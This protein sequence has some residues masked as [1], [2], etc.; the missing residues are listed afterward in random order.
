MLSEY[1]QRFS[2]YYT[3]LNRA[4]YLFRSGRRESR[5]LAQIFSEYSD[6][7]QLST[8]AELRAALQETAEYRET[9]RKSIQ[10][11]IA[12]ALQGNLASR[13]RE[14][15]DEIERYESN[16]RIDWD[17]VKIGFNRAS[18]LSAIE[19]EIIRRRDLH[20]RRADLITGSQDLRN[21]RIELLH[22]A[23][24][25]LNYETYLAMYRELRGIDYEKLAEQANRLLSKT[26]SQYVSALAPLLA[27]EAGT[28]LD[29]ATPPDAAY[30][31]RFTRFDN[32]FSSGRMI[33]VYRELC[34]GFGFK[35]ERQSNVE[36]EIEPQTGG[37]A[38][39]FSSP[40]RVPEEIKF[41]VKVAGGQKNYREF[42]RESGR[43][44]NFAW[45]SRQLYPE[46]R[47][48]AD[49]AVPEAWGMLLESLMLDNHWLLGTFGFVENANFR[50]ALELFRL[51]LL[52]R[53][54]ARLNYE[55]EFHA[56]RLSVNAGARYA[57][58]MTDA[59]RVR[60]DG[61]EHLR[62]LSDSFD[63]AS[64][65]RAW[66]FESQMREYLK[67]HFGSRWWTSR[68]AGEMLID[69]WN[70]GQRHSV[71]DLAAMVGLGELDFEWSAAELLEWVQK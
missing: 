40:I 1:R 50:H 51:M 57:E 56:G 38:S 17:G 53:N 28:S 5:E 32:F 41:A 54:A 7:F 25:A 37:R 10:R 58:L 65:L 33:E 26:E 13:V 20:A 35:T 63:P 12:F 16:A 18:E 52:R 22:G 2:T 67:T 48:G 62:D 59:L 60:Y 29:E 31:Q 6:L 69:L 70:T 24:R 43:V 45:T 36:I 71:E 46:F 27:R 39:T 21:E 55:V 9:E 11:L 64:F 15:S 30:L 42:L 23:A 61:T 68:K 49:Q 4:D 34:A 66:A 47:M 3:E 8:V 14:I 19:P 44:Q